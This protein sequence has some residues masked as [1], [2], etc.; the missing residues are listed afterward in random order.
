MKKHQKTLLA[1]AI[2]LSGLTGLHAQTTCLPDGIK[3]SSQAQ[4]D[5]FPVDYPG[6]TEIGRVYV[7]ED[8]FGDITNFNGLNS[9]EKI[10]GTLFVLS[11]A[12]LTDFSGLE[13]LTSI[14]DSLV[15]IANGALTSFNG[16][17]NLTEVNVSGTG[18]TIVDGNAVLTDLSSLG[19]LTTSVGNLVIASNPALET[20]AG[21]ESV[22]SF[23]NG[24]SVGILSIRDNASLTSLSPLMNMDQTTIGFMEIRDN[25][26]LSICDIEPICAHLENGGPAAIENNA[27]GCNTPQEVEVACQTVAVDDVGLD[28]L[29]QL[30]PN[31]TTGLV[32]IGAPAD[33]A[34]KVSV[35]D[36]MGR[37]IFQPHEWVDGAI[38][39][40]ALPAGVYFVEFND[41]GQTIGRRIVR[42]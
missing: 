5:A 8:A 35:R 40:S 13:N 29:I 20:L 26:N 22:V 32:Q 30:F 1:F 4:I 18:E 33:S 14:R 19:N 6:C 3:F 24:A 38:D 41:G 28:G 7:L 17:D 36:A 37:M 25:I 12:A 42:Q 11:N 34:W 31:P 10:E 27:P 9:I 2:G 15:V 23:G 21:L 39:L 16:L